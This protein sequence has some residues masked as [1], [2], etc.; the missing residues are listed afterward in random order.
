M[1][2]KFALLMCFV[3]AI[4]VFAPVISIF[5]AGKPDETPPALEKRI[6]IH[7]KKG[8][9]KPPGTPG[10]GP[11]SNGEDDHSDHY[12]LLGT[13]WKTTPVSYVIDPDNTQGLTEDF[14]G[15]AIFLSAEEWDAHT[16][17]ELFSN[18]YT[19]VHDATF[20][21]DAPDK[22][23]EILFG[24]YPKEGVIAVTIVW[25]YFSGPPGLRQIIEFDIMFDT[26]WTWGDA[27][28]D[29]TVMDLQNIA[30]HEL[31]H[32]AGLNDIYYCKLETMYGYSYYGELIKRDLY[33]GDIAGIQKL[34]G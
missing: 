3:L 19:V 32:G 17:T 20:D 11:P 26:D 33:I 25:G 12:A 27:S 22:R 21:T 31:G 6:F 18:T 29:S 13:K 4:I 14:I 28:I 5:S 16:E 9:G 7:Y 15:A 10:N 30:T 23:N 8:Y 2:R 1:K 24:N 34:Y